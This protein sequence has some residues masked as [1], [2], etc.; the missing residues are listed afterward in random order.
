[1]TPSE[2]Q[3]AALFDPLNGQTFETYGALEAAVREQFRIERRR[4]PSDFTYR[5]AISRARSEGWLDVRGGALAISNI[6]D[7]HETE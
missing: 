5:D 7:I 3:I 1:M 4:F 2:S 6:P